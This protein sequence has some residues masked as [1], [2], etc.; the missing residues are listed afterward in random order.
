MILLILTSILKAIIAWF[1]I[2]YVGTNLIGF[3][4]RGLWEERLDVNKLDL[5]D[6]PI[7][8]LAKKEIKRWNNSGDIITGLSFLATIGI[9][10]YLYSYWG[11]LFLIAIIITMASRAPDLYWEVR[12]LPKQLGIPYPVPKDLIRKAIKEDKNK[13]L[14]KTLLGLSSFATFVILFIAFFI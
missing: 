2:T 10:Y 12:V 14:F 3:I 13:S 7:K 9:C 8:D 5:S 4:G 6:N 11:T 1:I